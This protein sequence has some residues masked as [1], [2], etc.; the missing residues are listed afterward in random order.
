MVINTTWLRNHRLH[1]QEYYVYIT[2]FIIIV[3]SIR[4]Q[5]YPG[6]A[7]TAWAASISLLVLLKVFQQLAKLTLWIRHQGR[8]RS[9]FLYAAK[10]ENQHP[11]ALDYG[12]DSVGYYHHC[13]ALELGVH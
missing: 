3:F 5:D 10:A 12:V 7:N 6:N 2:V 8:R 9:E 13:C 4:Y 11:I 1:F